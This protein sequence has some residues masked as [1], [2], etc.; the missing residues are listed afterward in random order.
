MLALP[1]G[2]QGSK[3]LVFWS[4]DVL[5]Q[6]FDETAAK[7]DHRRPGEEESKFRVSASIFYTNLS[8]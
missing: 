7:V 4:V 8:S 1:P 2:R 6:C 3:Q 5:C